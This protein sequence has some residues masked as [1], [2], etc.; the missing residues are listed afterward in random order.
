MADPMMGMMGGGMGEEMESSPEAAEP[1]DD[2]TAAASEAFPDLAGDPARIAALKTA[3]SLCVEKD[4][5]GDYEESGSPKPKAD[6]LLAFGA[7][8]KKG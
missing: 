8:K 6:I 1:T 3:I 5:A 2:F 4:L 7:P